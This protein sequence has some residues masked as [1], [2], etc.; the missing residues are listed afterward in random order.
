M[1]CGG[2]V[3]KHLMQQAGGPVIQLNPVGSKTVAQIL[4][5]S[6]QVEHGQKMLQEKIEELRKLRMGVPLGAT[7]VAASPSSE[8][9]SAGMGGSGPRG[10]SLLGTLLENRRNGV[11]DW[12][13]DVDMQG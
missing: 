3:L 5:D 1:S 13:K 11:P 6:Q 8:V 10:P 2:L 9:S 4:G 12:L 7:T